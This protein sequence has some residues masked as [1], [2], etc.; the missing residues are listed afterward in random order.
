MLLRLAS[1]E[2]SEAARRGEAKLIY[3]VHFVIVLL[4]PFTYLGWRDG[5]ASGRILFGCKSA[6]KK[7]DR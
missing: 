7:I 2:A 4:S 6:K 3:V 1:A 5:R